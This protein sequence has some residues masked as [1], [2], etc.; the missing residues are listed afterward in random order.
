MEFDTLTLSRL[1]F[2]LTIM[3]HYLFP[4]LSIGLGTLMV[5]MEGWYLRTGD[6][7][8]QAMTKFWT[9]I[10]AA[11]FAVGVA[12]G[13]VMEFQFGTNWSRYSRFVGDVFGSALAA[14]GIFAFFLESGFLAVLVFGWDRVSPR[15]HFIATLMVA[16][17]SMFS[18]V[19]IVIANSWQHTPAGYHIVMHAGRPRAE[20]DDFWAMVFNPSSMHRLGH[21][22][23]GA[24]I[25][26]AFFV[27]SVQA[28][29]LLQ[30]KHEQFAR[31]GFT[32]AL[33][34]A[35]ISSLLMGLSGHFQARKVAETQPAKLAAFEGHFHQGTGGTEMYLF[36]LPNVREERVE[37]GIAVPG[38]LS[39]LVYDDWTRP[40]RALDQ[41]PKEDRPPV[42]I[43]FI[44]YH[45]MAMLGGF[46]V[47]ITVL[48]LGLWFW[49]KLFTQRWLLW[50]FVFA[51]ITPYIANQAGWVAAEVGRQPWVVYGLLRTS[52][53]FSPSVSAG[54]VAASIVMFGFVY[55]LLFAVWVYVIHGKIQHGPDPADLGPQGTGMSDIYAA[56][57]RRGDPGKYSLTQPDKNPPTS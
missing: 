46:F 21:V 17:G 14:E 18:A 12:T 34:F 20:I 23:L 26:G 11:N 40:V 15:M 28:W 7:D 8:Y 6:P 56:A 48:A 32:M 5:L 19:W 13:L 50:V 35:A 10:F 3:F 38:L 54:E 2:A 1:Q 42:L 24:Y 53:A 25:L 52:D 47:G 44:T 55:L 45:V 33:W 49:G 41:F 31:K 36:G 43:P 22:I 16:I 27:M 4:P 30:R 29:Y 37:F 51:V 39:F 57:A 9:K